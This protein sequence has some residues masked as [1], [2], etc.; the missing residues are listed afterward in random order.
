MGFK[1]M[2]KEVSALVQCASLSDPL[3]Q[4]V[5]KAIRD[6]SPGSSLQTPPHSPKKQDHEGSV[7]PNRTPPNSPSVVTSVRKNS[8]KRPSVTKSGFRRFTPKRTTPFRMTAPIGSPTGA[9][10]S[11][12]PGVIKEDSIG[13]CSGDSDEEDDGTLIN[14]KKLFF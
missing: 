7:S 8:E 2:A 13:A 4:E 5:I 3:V 10:N 6:L 12:S 9:S 1:E 14:P 11:L